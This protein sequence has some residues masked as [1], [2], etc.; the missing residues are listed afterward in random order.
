MSKVTGIVKFNLNICV[1]QEFCEEICKHKKMYLSSFT[2]GRFGKSGMMSL[3]VPGVG[4]CG[5][6]LDVLKKLA[7]FLFL[8]LLFLWVVF[9]PPPPFFPFPFFP[10]LL[11]FSVSGICKKEISPKELWTV[12]NI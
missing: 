8:G 10:L 3:L 7:V 11:S 1:L 2:C 6:R 4:V 9:P 12:M 5:C